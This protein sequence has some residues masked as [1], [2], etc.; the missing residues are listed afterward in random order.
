MKRAVLLTGIYFHSLGNL[1][2][3][4]NVREPQTTNPPKNFLRQLI[5]ILFK[6][7]FSSSVKFTVNPIIPFNV[8]SRPAGA[9]HTPCSVS[10]RA[11]TPAITPHGG[12]FLGLFSSSLSGYIIL[13]KNIPIF[14]F[15]GRGK[16][17][18]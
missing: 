12:K 1:F 4:F 15:L 16:V 3:P 5:P 2:S 8:A 11:I 7:S 18:L 9:F 13:G 10:V 14:S 6:A 17:L